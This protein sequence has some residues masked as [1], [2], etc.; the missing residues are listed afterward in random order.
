LVLCGSVV[1]L[2]APAAAQTA[3][4]VQNAEGPANSNFGYA[5][6]VDGNTA[7]IGA[8]LE[9]SSGGAAYVVVRSG[10]TWVLQQRLQA[11]DATSSAQFGSS[12]AI[13]GETLIVGST[14]GTHRRRCDWRGLRLRQKRHDVGAAGEADADDT[15]PRQLRRVRRGH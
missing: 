5:I 11:D 3:A 7:V 6:A 15:H 1:A 10:A 12:V 2:A 4:F 14:V 13:S 8:R 9:S